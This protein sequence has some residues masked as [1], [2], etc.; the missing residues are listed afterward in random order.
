MDSVP[1][2][3]MPGEPWMMPSHLAKAIT[4]GAAGPWAGF[5]A[6]VAYARAGLPVALVEPGGKRPVGGWDTATADPEAVRDRFVAEPAGNVGLAAGGDWIAFDIDP[7]HGG[8]L[9]TLEAA[10]VPIDGYRE[11]SAGDGWHLYFTMPAGL[12]ATRGA[13]VAPGV[14]AKAAGQG[15]VTPHSRLA[16]G[17]RWR[18]DDGVRFVW[19]SLSP[20]LPWLD[21]LTAPRTLAAAT[22]TADD[23]RDASDVL[24]AL[25]GS[26]FAPLVAAILSDGRGPYPSRSEADAG[27]A[28]MASHHLRDHPRRA[29]VLCALLHRHSR[30]RRDHATPGRYIAVTVAAAETDRDRRDADRLTRIRAV[31]AAGQT[32]ASSPFPDPSQPLARVP[33]CMR[34]H[35]RLAG[36]KRENV[37]VGAFP[38]GHDITQGKAGRRA[39]AVLGFLAGAAGSEWAARDGWTRLPVTDLATLLD[40]DR[41]TIRRDVDRLAAAGLIETT[42]RCRVHD[43][44]ARRDRW[45]RVRSPPAGGG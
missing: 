15:I 36:E 3:I 20:A 24:R 17:R 27:L 41:S 6:A 11:R 21:A 43:G 4:A 14:E 39:S 34:A 40:V 29:E 16:D 42:V 35:A 31:I 12:T 30:K 18:V 25:A 9:E 37:T 33:A 2:P 13:T 1:R 28:L 38:D 5:T 26:R 8:R 22:V 44:R 32:L 10:G 19:P 23:E 7:R 45:A